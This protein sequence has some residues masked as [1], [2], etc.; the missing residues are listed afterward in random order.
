MLYQSHC[1]PNNAIGPAQLLWRP[2]QITSSRQLWLLIHPAIVDKLLKEFTE[3]VKSLATAGS[4]II[5]NLRDELVH[6]KL[7]G[8][9]CND[10]IIQTIQPVWKPGDDKGPASCTM[11]D[12][13]LVDK[14]KFFSFF[15]QA[16]S[17]A[18]LPNKTIVGLTV[19]D[20]RLSSLPKNIA[21]SPQST[22][23]NTGNVL[24]IVTPKLSQCYIW[25]KTVRDSVQQAMVPQC[26]IDKIRS[27]KLRDTSE[28]LKDLECQLPILLLHQTVNGTGVGWDILLPAKWGMS[29]WLSLVYNGA[30]VIGF[31]EMKVYHLEQSILHFPTDYPDTDAGRQLELNNSKTLQSKYCKYPPDKRPNF[32]KLNSPSPFLPA[33]S[34]CCYE[35]VEQQAVDTAPVAKRAKLLP[36]KPSVLDREITYYVLRSVKL[37][38]SLSNLLD[39]LKAVKTS[40]TTEEGWLSILNDMKL[41]TVAVDHYNSLVAI[42]FVMYHRGNPMARSMLCI[43]L[44]EDLL[45]LSQNDS[46]HGYYGPMELLNKKGVSIQQTNRLV[47]GTTSLTNKELKSAR[48]DLKVSK[49][50]NTEDFS[51]HGNQSNDINT[52]LKLQPIKSSRAI[53]GYVTNAGYVFSQ[54]TGAG[55]G[56]CSLLGLL[57][58]LKLC[59]LQNHPVTLLVREHDSLQ[60]RFAFINILLNQF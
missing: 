28:E 60:Y 38:V 8:A 6:Y 17:P 16:K 40:I 45:K 37:L 52:T 1:Y 46:C 39:S 11:S 9:C 34:N 49:S 30:R 18:E 2:D 53:I 57:D 48:R 31:E 44:I 3:N 7:I 22:P 59:Y 56:L 36:E 20:F 29:L 23:T 47:T 5:T 10:V 12:D 55:V 26:Q 4:V 58:L 50:Q 42:S 41:S 27:D 24:E 33:W 54:G 13:E 15:S 51:C 19:R 43:P 25:S 14:K 21:S 32:G 35:L